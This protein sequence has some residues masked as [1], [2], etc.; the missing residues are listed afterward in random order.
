[1]RIDIL[2]NKG[3]MLSVFDYSSS[4]VRGAPFSRWLEVR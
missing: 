1:M 3:V 4:G 2:K